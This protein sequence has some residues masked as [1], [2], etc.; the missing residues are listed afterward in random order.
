VGLQRVVSAVSIP[1]DFNHESRQKA[2]ISY[3]CLCV[4]LLPLVQWEVVL[5]AT[6]DGVPQVEEV[7]L[8]GV[9][10]VALLDEVVV[11]A[12]PLALGEEEAARALVVE[13]VLVEV[14]E[15]QGEADN[16][17]RQAHKDGALQPCAQAPTGKALDL[18]ERVL[19]GRIC[20]EG[21]CEDPSDTDI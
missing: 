4:T 2:Y 12:D 14:A 17:G 1:G 11:V 10:E 13:V 8:Q 21:S 18:V 15:D 5:G 16:C 9:E 3:S 6:A 7:V 19:Q 20:M